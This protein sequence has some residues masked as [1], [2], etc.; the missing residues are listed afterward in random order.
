MEVHLP[1][2]TLELMETGVKE[3]TVSDVVKVKIEEMMNNNEVIH[4][5][6]LWT[7]RRSRTWR[8]T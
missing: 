5:R 4:G 1:Q 8:S 6:R 2:V 3:E 7:R